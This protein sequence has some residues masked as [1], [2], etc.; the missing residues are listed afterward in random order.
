MYIY[1]PRCGENS[2]WKYWLYEMDLTSLYLAPNSQVLLNDL[3]LFI[4]FPTQNN[5]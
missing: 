1:E 5:P 3:P 2:K 4:S